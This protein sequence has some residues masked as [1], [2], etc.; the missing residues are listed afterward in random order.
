MEIKTKQRWRY[1]DI[2]NDSA[3][4]LSI[5]KVEKW[6]RK[7]IYKCNKRK[8]PQKS[9]MF[10]KRN[11]MLYVTGTLKTMDRCLSN[12]KGKNLNKL[13]TVVQI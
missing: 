5:S 3:K 8:F 1:K 11:L 10:I 13:D 6:K 4:G 2:L 9:I 12:S 7:S